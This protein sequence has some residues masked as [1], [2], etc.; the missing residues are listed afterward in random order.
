MVGDES[1]LYVVTGRGLT[2]INQETGSILWQKHLP[3]EGEFQDLLVMQEERLVV[4]ADVEPFA[5]EQTIYALDA[6]TGKVKWQVKITGSLDWHKPDPGLQTRQ[7]H[8]AI[9]YD[10]GRVYL[11]T[12]WKDAVFSSIV[13]LDANDGTALWHFDFGIKQMPGDAPSFAADTLLL[14]DT[15]V[16]IPIFLGPLYVVDSATGT[17][18]GMRDEWRI[19]PVLIQDE[20]VT[21]VSGVGAVALDD[22]SFQELWFHSLDEEIIGIPEIVAW[23]D[24]IVVE[25]FP[26]IKIFE[27]DLGKQVGSII[28]DTV[29]KSEEALTIGQ[30]DLHLC[31][32]TSNSVY[33]FA[34]AKNES[35]ND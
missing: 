8:S 27:A 1:K 16:Y 32:I 18:I 24:Y 31:L 29:G 6:R 11:R 17:L 3:V 30:C 34:V 4:Y 21:Y 7:R 12:I 35:E 25:D 13:A 10:K 28:A 20:I 14:T 9:R 23:D 26:T 22:Q 19:S 5:R 2:A 15:S 33:V